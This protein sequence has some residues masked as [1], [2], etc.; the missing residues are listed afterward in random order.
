MSISRRSYM[1]LNYRAT[2]NQRLGRRAGKSTCGLE[3]SMTCGVSLTN[4]NDI[5][6][7]LRL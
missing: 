4:I 2:L 3:V 7:T 6:P 5:S 1:S